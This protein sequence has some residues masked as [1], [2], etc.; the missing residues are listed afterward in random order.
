MA[1]SPLLNLKRLKATRPPV[2]IRLSEADIKKMVTRHGFVKK[3]CCCSM[4]IRVKLPW[5]DENLFSERFIHRLAFYLNMPYEGRNC[6][7]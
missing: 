3:I 2:H 4:G 5:D 1:V 6:N 7:P